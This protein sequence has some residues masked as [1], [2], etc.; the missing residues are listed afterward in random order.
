M[1]H[2]FVQLLYAHIE[3]SLSDGVAPVDSYSDDEIEDV[4][5]GWID[6]RCLQCVRSGNIMAVNLVTPLAGHLT[7]LSGA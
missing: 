5:D 7:L 3:F 2:Y 4:M 1:F 6:G